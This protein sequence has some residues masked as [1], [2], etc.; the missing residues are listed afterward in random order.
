MIFGCNE[1]II[2]IAIEGTGR[3]CNDG[4]E[5]PDTL[6][7]CWLVYNKNQQ[8]GKPLTIELIPALHFRLIAFAHY[9]TPV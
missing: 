6:Q 7:Q 8:Q 3:G 1:L 5:G 2:S 9:S 4:G